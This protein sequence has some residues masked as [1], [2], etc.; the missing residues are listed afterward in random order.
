MATRRLRR[1][2]VHRVAAQRHHL[3]SRPEPLHRPPPQRGD[4]RTRRAAIGPRRR[5]LRERR[6][7][8][9]TRTGALLRNTAA[10]I[11]AFVAA[12]FV[13]PQLTGL[14]TSISNDLTQYLP[15]NAGTARRRTRPRV[16]PVGWFGRPLRLRRHP[17]S[18]AAYRHDTATRE[19]PSAI[20]TDAEARW[21]PFSGDLELL[22]VLEEVLNAPIK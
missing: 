7:H 20:R 15:A 21:R 5:P 9:R 3:L 4:H 8:H 12:Y 6:R 18:A 16:V 14:P 2:R 10:A 11:S 1:R 22:R 17:D 13:V 19:T